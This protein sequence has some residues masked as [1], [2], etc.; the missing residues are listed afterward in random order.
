MYHGALLLLLALGLGRSLHAQVGAGG[1]PPSFDLP[2]AGPAPTIALPGVDHAALLAED[3]AAPK[4]EALR[5]GAP[6]DRS[7]DL[8]RQG[9]RLELPDGGSLWRLRLT[10]PGALSL[11]L[12][13]DDFALPPGA[14][15]FLYNDERSML[16]GAFTDF[17]NKPGGQFATQPVAGDAVTLEYEE[18]ATCPWPGRVRVCRV[19]HAYR[20]LLG[21]AERD[22][23]DSG[24]CNN[25]VACPV[26]DD[27]RTEIRAVAMIL[28]GSGFR[29]CS[30]ALVNNTG[31]DMR[32]F[33]LTAN[34][35]LG[36]E[37]NW[38][39]MFNY[40]SPGC[41]NQN[42]PTTDSVQGCVRRANLA[43]SDFA[44]LEL[45]EAI[46]EDYRVVYAGWSNED[47]APTRGV[48][49]HHPSGDIKKISF[50]D[51]AL[52]SDRYLGNQGVAGSH[53]RVI[54]WDDGT[55][56]AG[57]SGSPV[58]DQNHHVV[59]QL[60]GGYASC[61]SQTSDWYGKFAMSWERGG[62]P[63]TRLRDWLDPL[64]TGQ[65]TLGPLDTWSALQ[66]GYVSQQVLATDDGD[67]V[68]EPG[69]TVTLAVTLLSQET[70]PVDGVAGVLSSQTPWLAV[71][72][73]G[74]AWP[75]MQPG[76]SGANLTPF[77]L[78]VAEDA[79]QAGE[80]RL[81]LTMTQGA[82]TT[83]FAL[84]LDAGSRQIYW[85]DDAESGENGWSHAAGA[86]W[87]DAWHLDTQDAHSASHA[88]KCGAVGAG[89]YGSHL[90]ARLDSPAITLWPWSRLR[91][92]QRIQ[93][94]VAATYPDSA[95]DAGRLEISADDGATWTQL[96]PET[97]YTH[98]VR[99]RGPGGGQNNQPLPP[100]SPCWSGDQ[101]WREARVDLAAWGGQSVRLRWR[102]GSDNSGGALGWLVDDVTLEGLSPPPAPVTDLAIHWLGNAQAR[103]DWSPTANAT[104]Y[105]VECRDGEG[106]VWA[107]LAVVA[108]PGLT[109]PA[110]GRRF[111]RVIAMNE[112]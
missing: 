11:N 54:D 27:W 13:Y 4:D 21:G 77:A 110:T 52:V 72:Q 80:A 66:L 103:L 56:E 41:A 23:G 40:Q 34:H 96:M 63:A 69:E 71:T 94:Q 46:P 112:N 101:S 73:G 42:G 32:Q 16:I 88:W 6:L 67:L 8:R 87:N 89:N 58:F 19:V 84:T 49:I 61:T 68:P 1:V 3:E 45:S 7:I 83:V 93:A 33:L 92:W 14:R 55:T 57:S 31:Q 39:F 105:R 29:I 65:T 82:D 47:V 17:N 102:F 90:D 111:F 50:E 62:A 100:F 64:D 86:G 107:T 12:L 106:Q 9:Q 37:T 97:G 22:Y 95:Y 10:S 26:G 18:P 48:G 38:I 78:Q 15:L 104:S 35:C 24:S 59:G 44:L 75:V 28:E 51:Q 74:S 99:W 85:Q 109:V 91:F 36:G 43:D 25:N 60:H 30:G 2:G 76:G 98:V 79:P 70:A 53:W 20:D 81:T 108:E 5:F